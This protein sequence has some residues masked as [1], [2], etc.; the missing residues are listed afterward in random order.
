MV[1]EL[2]LGEAFSLRLWLKPKRWEHI[3]NMFFSPV[4]FDT[5]QLPPILNAL[6]TT[7]GGQKLVLEVAVSREC[8]MSFSVNTYA[9]SYI[10]TSG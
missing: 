4:K 10:A 8:S 9:N 7:N 1:S 5:E 6:E 2:H 3:L